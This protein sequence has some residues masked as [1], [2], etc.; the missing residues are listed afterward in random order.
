MIWGSARR[1][2]RAAQSAKVLLRHFQ[3]A[4]AGLNKQSAGLGLW[5]L[6]QPGFGICGC[7][8]SDTG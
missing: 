1:H 6:P 3:R 2:S 8:L 5:P 7:T 4:S